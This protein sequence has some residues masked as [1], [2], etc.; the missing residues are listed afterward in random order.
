M[1]S[2]LSIL[3]RAIFIFLYSSV[4]LASTLAGDF[5]ADAPAPDLIR[6]SNGYNLEDP[7]SFELFGTGLFDPSGNPKVRALEVAELNFSDPTAKRGN[8]SY[9]VPEPATMLLLGT[10]LI[11][12]A[13]IGHK[14]FIIKK[15]RRGRKKRWKAGKLEGW[16]ARRR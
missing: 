1:K 2:I 3:Y 6:Q 9:P 7:W 16:E 4:S 13:S 5:K 14:K 8:R 12:I 15:D 10:G 11:A